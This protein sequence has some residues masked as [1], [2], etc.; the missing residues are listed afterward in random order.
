MSGRR[1]LCSLFALVFAVERVSLGKIPANTV[2]RRTRESTI[3]CSTI[4]GRRRWH[5]LVGYTFL[6]NG[7]A[8]SIEAILSSRLPRA[9]SHDEK[10]AEF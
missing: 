4:A 10:N 5:R 1:N 8:P 7:G 3:D 2:E 9:I 6:W